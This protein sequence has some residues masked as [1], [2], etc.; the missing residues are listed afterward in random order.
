MSSEVIHI[1]GSGVGGCRNDE[2]SHIDGDD[3]GG[4]DYRSNRYTFTFYSS[5][6]DTASNLPG[7]GRLLGNVYSYAGRRLERAVGIVAHKSGFGPNATYQK[8]QELMQAGWKDD[9]KKSKLFDIC[10]ILSIT[11]AYLLRT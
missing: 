3:D 2:P 8:M 1:T 10:I 11:N 4:R 6:N 5:T 7:P 9:H